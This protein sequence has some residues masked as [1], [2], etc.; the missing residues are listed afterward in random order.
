M[1]ISGVSVHTIDLSLS[2]SLNIC[3]G[4]KVP[5]FVRCLV[6]ALF[7]VVVPVLC[8]PGPSDELP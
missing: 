5:N 6:P 8:G 1:C 3:H 2:Q 4:S 7:V